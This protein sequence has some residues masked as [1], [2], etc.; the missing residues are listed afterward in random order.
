MPAVIYLDIGLSGH[1]GLIATYSI[2]HSG[3]AVMED[4]EPGSTQENLKSAG[5]FHYWHKDRT[6][7]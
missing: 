2:P 5:L 6:G 3:G 7:G 1:A 4:P